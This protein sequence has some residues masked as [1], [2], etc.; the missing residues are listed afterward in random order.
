MKK[1]SK[2]TFI[3]LIILLATF[4][5]S[6]SAEEN[7]QFN[8]STEEKTIEIT[9]NEDQELQNQEEADKIE[10][11]S[12]TEKT[13]ERMT[14]GQQNKK[15]VN[16][17]NTPNKAINTVANTADYLITNLDLSN[18]SLYTFTIDEDNSSVYFY[19][20]TGIK[21]YSVLT[22]QM[23]TVVDFEKPQDDQ[24]YANC[25]SENIFYMLVDSTTTTQSYHVQ[26]YDLVQKKKVFDKKFNVN[27]EPTINLGYK[28]LVDTNQN[29]YFVTGKRVITSYDKNG[30]KLDTVTNPLDRQI[31]LKQLTPDGK[32]LIFTTYL[33]NYQL[34]SGYLAVEN[35]K[36]L[37]YTGNAFTTYENV[38]FWLNDNFHYNLKFN[39]ECTF[40]FDSAGHIFKYK[41]VYEDGFRKTWFSYVEDSNT[42]YYNSTYEL[43]MFL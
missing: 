1:I 29:F 39:K 38:P 15:A 23:E 13:E 20:A 26:G 33:E 43:R 2:K 19:N 41:F 28:F 14:I 16:V 25:V 10:G 12:A 21:K 8:Y 11:S 17:L 27:A 6:V 32:T 35:G 3:I 18:W 31:G 22:K 7:Y 40:A 5:T 9:E 4:A 37:R 36:F 34:K 24:L 30:N 42:S